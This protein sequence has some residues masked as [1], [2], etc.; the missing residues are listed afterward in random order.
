MSRDHAHHTPKFRSNSSGVKMM[1]LYNTLTLHQSQHIL[2]AQRSEEQLLIG[3]NQIKLQIVAYINRYSTSF[4]NMVIIN[5]Y[6]V[7]SRLPPSPPAS[8]SRLSRLI[9]WASLGKY[10]QNVES[11][12]STTRTTPPTPASRFYLIPSMTLSAG[13]P[14]QPFRYFQV[15]LGTFR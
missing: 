6:Q 11:S 3:I 9:G 1:S 14:L 4:T 12:A 7:S 10:N 5:D 8:I 15:T 2:C 13:G